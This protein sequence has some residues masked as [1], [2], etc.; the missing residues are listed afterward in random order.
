MSSTEPCQCPPLRP[1]SGR[2]CTKVDKL[3]P[4]R[5]VDNEAAAATGRWGIGTNGA[6]ALAYARGKCVY[7][8]HMTSARQYWFF[9][10]APAGAKF[11]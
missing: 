6:R 5:S 8:P 11:C 9:G 7:P 4:A 2:L 3:G 1:V 10:S